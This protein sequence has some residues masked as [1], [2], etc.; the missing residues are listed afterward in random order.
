MC[1]T[2]TKSNVG[3][4]RAGSRSVGEMDFYLTNTF[5]KIAPPP[6][7]LSTSFLRPPNRPVFKYEFHE[8]LNR[9]AMRGAPQSAIKSDSDKQNIPLV[10]HYETSDKNQN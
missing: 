9:T 5:C 3:S 8:I 10:M 4:P 7:S 1:P 6:L 2:S